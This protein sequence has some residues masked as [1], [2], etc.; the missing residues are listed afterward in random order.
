MMSHANLHIGG[1]AVPLSD[2]LEV[3]FSKTLKLMKM[4]S[5]NVK[6]KW[7]RS[8]RQGL[9]LMETLSVINI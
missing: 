6:M 1:S 3:S 5:V 9:F 7:W 2:G 8:A 4:K